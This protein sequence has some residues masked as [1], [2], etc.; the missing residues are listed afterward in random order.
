MSQQNDD[1]KDLGS[2]KINNQQKQSDVNE[3]FSGENLPKNYDPSADK[4]KTELDK[5]TDGKAVTEQRAR[6]TDEKKA[7]PVDS[8]E[9]HTTRNDG[10]VVSKSRGTKNESEDMETAEN[11][12]FN[13][14]TE[15]DR[16]PAG[17]PENKKVRGNTHL[18]K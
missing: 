13:S 12:D 7:P 4:L 10:E 16:Y 5:R 1:P 18:G 14:D 11:R 6:D 9:G 2:K 17:H 15:E 8:N 3:G